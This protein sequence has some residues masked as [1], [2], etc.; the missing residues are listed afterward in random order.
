MVIVRVEIP[1][2]RR[3]NVVTPREMERYWR[4]LN[5]GFMTEESDDP[6]NPNGIVEHRLLWR[7]QS[8]L[9]FMQLHNNYLQKLQNLMNLWSIWMVGKNKSLC[10]L[11]WS[12]KKLGDTVSLPRLILR[13][14]L[15]NG[16][17]G[18]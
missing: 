17:Y 9:V 2:E 13:P 14:M 16:L 11:D 5:L 10:L 15:Q 3:A 6:E 7:S 4:H 8:K 1:E 18:L 12:P